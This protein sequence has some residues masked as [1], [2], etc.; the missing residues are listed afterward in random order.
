MFIL[1]SIALGLGVLLTTVAGWLGYQ[2]NLGANVPISVARFETTLSSKITTTDTSMTLVTGSDRGLN[3]LNGRVCFTLDGGKTTEEFVCGTA[4]S[5]AVTAMTRGI[6]YTNPNSTSSS[7]IFEHRA[8]SNVKITDW[9][10]SGINSRIL[11]GDDTLPNTISYAT[12]TASFTTD[13]QIPSKKYVDSLMIAGMTDANFTTFGG[14][15]IATTGQFYNG[16]ATGTATRYLVPP[17]SFF[18]TTSGAYKGVV[19]NASGKISQGWLNLTEP[20]TFT[21]TTTFASTTINNSLSITGTTT[22]NNVVFNNYPADMKFYATSTSATA[23]ASLQGSMD[24]IVS[25]TSVTSVALEA[26]IIDSFLKGKVLIA[27]EYRNA[28]TGTPN[29]DVYTYTS[30]RDRTATKEY[31]SGTLTHLTGIPDDTNYN[32][33]NDFFNNVYLGDIIQIRVYTG[34]VNQV[35][36]IKNFRIYYTDLATTTPEVSTTTY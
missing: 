17:A 19:A 26:F 3:A 12:D 36:G 9:P 30:H 13:I 14:V 16:V 5:T 23:T 7:L 33:E 21:A 4:S 34:N 31:A 24:A 32:S 6:S 11:N 15:I 35:A 27:Y 20:Y 29:A 8:G 22:L 2:Q 28:T 25:T 1:K 18:N 10:Q